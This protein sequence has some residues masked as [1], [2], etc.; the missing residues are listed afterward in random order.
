MR[1]LS[2]QNR[3]ATSETRAATRETRAATIPE[4][5]SALLTEAAR[6]SWRALSWVVALLTSWGN[7]SAAI[8][9][10]SALFAEL[11]A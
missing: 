1:T 11:L 10:L 8:E 3:A 6:A 7:D 2:A 5:L 4:L 9:L